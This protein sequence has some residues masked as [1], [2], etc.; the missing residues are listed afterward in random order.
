M[1][2]ETAQATANPAPG[3]VALPASTERHG[4]MDRSQAVQ[5]IR[6]HRE[7]VE[8]QPAKVDAPK[9]NPQD[10]PASPAVEEPEAVT[11]G[12]E[13]PQAS[14]SETE[15]ATEA[16]VTPQELAEF[17]VDE[18]AGALE[19]D[20][21]DLASK[22]RVPIKINGETKLVTLA[23][24]QAGHQLEADYRQKTAEVAE[25]RRALQA[26]VEQATQELRAKFQAADDLIS[27]LGAKVQSG[28]T[29]EQLS[30]LRETDPIEYLRVKDQVESDRA[31][32]L[33]AMRA[34]QQERAQLEA[35][36]SQDKAK[37]RGEQTKA[38]TAM[39]DF[40]TPEKVMKFETDARSALKDHY[41]FRETEVEKF[42]ESYDVRQVGIV[43]DAIKYRQMMKGSVDLK[44]VLKSK[45]KFAAPG[46]SKASPGKKS[47]NVD[48]L[49]T[50]LA[51]AKT[52]GE[53][54]T[55]ALAFLKA[56]RNG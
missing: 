29:Q 39:P 45:P 44:E 27:I 17:T 31:A 19:L 48:A 1:T 5:I 9:V 53:R 47:E 42:F 55:A 18:L 3:A 2:I 56:K 35:K 46:P 26:G 6:Q 20:P 28:P 21:K 13:E 12:E 34:R 41:G 8:S 11:H 54:K 52:S 22:L 15:S 40:D 43:R 24:A 36:Q 33:Q 10:T 7:H 23:E 38:L 30:H 37:W 25:Q 16:T 32:L 51:K 14:A 50:R 49:R 4:T